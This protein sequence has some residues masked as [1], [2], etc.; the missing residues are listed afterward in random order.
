MADRGP[1]WLDSQENTYILGGHFF[2]PRTARSRKTPIGLII[3]GTLGGVTFAF[4]ASICAF[5]Y[6][7]R[8]KNKEVVQATHDA[9]A[10]VGADG[11][12]KGE[13]DVSDSL[14]ASTV[15]ALGSPPSPVH[16]HS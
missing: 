12:E 9:E 6:L 7:R 5:S 10:F 2:D 1:M 4:L 8:K 15:N 3:G 13:L 11:H 16:H 14:S